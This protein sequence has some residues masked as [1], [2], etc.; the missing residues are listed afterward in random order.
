MRLNQAIARTGYCAR[1]KADELIAAGK[2]KVNGEVVMDFSRQIDPDSDDLV[3]EGKRLSFSHSIYI[4][5]NKPPG[6]VTTMSDESGR[7]TVI[8]LLPG[9]LKSLRPVGRLDMYSEGLL[10]LTNDGHLAQRL[11]HPS[12]HL[13]KTYE[14]E[15]RG[16]ISDK[17]LQM[18]A[19]GVELEDGRTL[20]A[21]VKLISRNKTY[22]EFEI[23]IR[24]GRNRQIRR[25]C[26]LLGYSVVRLRRLGIG[27]LRLGLIPTGSWRYLTDAEVRLLFPKQKRTD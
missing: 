2:V 14:V 19:S 18:M 13:L 22:S 7:E 17:H 27:M 10:I 4:A 23:S 1:R 9:K 20:P 24:E 26:S 16:T 21:K 12:M 8:D 15:V 25:M 6:V 5:M 11:T 3:V